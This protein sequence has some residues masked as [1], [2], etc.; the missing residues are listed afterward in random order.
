MMHTLEDVVEAIISQTGCMMYFL[1]TGSMM[2]VL[3]ETSD[4]DI[5]SRL[6]LSG[7]DWTL[8]FGPVSRLVNWTRQNLLS[9]P[10]RVIDYQRPANCLQTKTKT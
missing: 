3:S 4:E 2:Y 6:L 10:D 9:V 1:Q 7:I 5:T 8:R